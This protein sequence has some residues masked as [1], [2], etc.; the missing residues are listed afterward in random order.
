MP[1]IL[2]YPS[3][4]RIF[5]IALKFSFQITHENQS[6][7]INTISTWKAFTHSI[8]CC[9]WPQETSKYLDA[10]QGSEV[11]KFKKNSDFFLFMS[12]GP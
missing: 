1:N 7:E 3:E 2:M 9:I 5:G 6:H 4:Q 12:M 11:R 8:I 10:C